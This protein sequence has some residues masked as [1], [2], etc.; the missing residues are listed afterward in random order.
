MNAVF[1]MHKAILIL[2]LQ[3]FIVSCYMQ[4]TEGSSVAHP[5]KT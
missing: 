1:H 4:I 5:R 2:V 3:V